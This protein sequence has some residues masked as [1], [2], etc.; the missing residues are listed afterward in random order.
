[1]PIK[2][3]LVPL[4]GTDSDA[5]ALATALMA[6]GRFDAH[7]EALHARP[8]PKDMVGYMTGTITAGPESLR[9]SVLEAAL[10]SADEQAKK[11]R[12]FL[13]E[14]CAANNV[15]MVEEPPGAGGASVAWIEDMGRE[16]DVVV[17]HSRFADLLVLPR[18]IDHAQKAATLEISLMDNRRRILVAPPVAPKSLGDKIAVAWNGSAEAARAVTAAMQ[19]LAGSNAVTVL[20]TEKRAET[21]G[22]LTRYLTW[23]GIAAETRLF[24]TGSLSAGEAILAA[25][26]HM[27]ADL[28][29]MGGYGHSRMQERILGGVTQHALAHAEI[30]LFMAH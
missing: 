28:L 16:S 4:N 23:H 12:A 29:V 2:T 1:M 3:I 6:A 10:S 15:P 27:G 14:Q 8:N 30:P 17:R 22:A 21:V 19:F 11:V 5:P 7:V 18:P 24:K 9:Q 20:T 13:E 26:E 25:T